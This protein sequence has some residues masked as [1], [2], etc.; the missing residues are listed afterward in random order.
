ML[1]SFTGIPSAWCLMLSSNSTFVGRNEL[2]EHPPC[3]RI[4]GHCVTKI[5]TLPSRDSY[6][7][8][9]PP[10]GLSG[11]EVYAGYCPPMVG[12]LPFQEFPVVDINGL[13]VFLYTGCLF[14]SLSS[15]ISLSL[16]C[17]LPSLNVQMLWSLS[18]S[19]TLNM[20]YLRWCPYSP[21]D[22]WRILQW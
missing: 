12:C 1:I 6:S 4:W 22:K 21:V 9:I 14:P 18:F 3:V 15:Y 16:E 20:D 11:G 13:C 2:V 17:C 10:N 5:Q 8:I 7:K 19:E